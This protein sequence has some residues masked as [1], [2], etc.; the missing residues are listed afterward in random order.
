MFLYLLVVLLSILLFLI[1]IIIFN[2]LVVFIW[3]LFLLN[4][5]V[6]WINLVLFLRLIWCLI[7]IG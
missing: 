5:G 3:K 2:E 1:C 4:K 7:I 6:M